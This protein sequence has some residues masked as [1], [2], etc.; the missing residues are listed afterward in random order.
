[1]ERRPSATNMSTRNVVRIP[2][3][4]RTPGIISY[5]VCTY[6]LPARIFFLFRVHIMSKYTNTTTV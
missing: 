4:H 3:V 6:L 1:M 5:E 2:L